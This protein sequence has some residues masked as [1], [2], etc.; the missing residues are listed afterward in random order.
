MGRFVLLALV[1]VS[2]GAM[3]ARLQTVIS[4]LKAPVWMTQAPGQPDRFYVVE[5]RGRILAVTRGS[6]EKQV[7]LDI[8]R[9]VV[10][11]GE[12]GLLSVAFH[13]DFARNG[14]YFVNYTA[15]TPSFGNVIAEYTVGSSEE[16]VLLHIP[17]PWTNHN[18]GLLLFGKDGYLY[19]GTGDGGDAG[20]PMG[21]G[22]N[23]NALLAKILRI[24]V[25]SGDPYGIPADNPFA[26]GGGRG[27]VY[28]Y[29]LRNPWRFSFDRVTNALFAGDVGQDKWEEIDV[30]E[31]GGN[32][33]WNTMEGNHCFNPPSGC[34]TTGLRL[35]IWEYPH[36]E[37][38][39]VIG[40]YVYRGS[41]LPELRGAYVYGDYGNGRIWALRYDQRSRETVA[42]D[43]LLE[44]RLP[45]SSFAE[46]DRGELYVLALDGK[47]FKIA[48]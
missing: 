34:D 45:I 38:I 40:G 21:N 47:V 30:V 11:G 43:L 8:R 9:N 35:P 48:K 37:G 31:K 6:G 26:Q 32:Y 42:N 44:S 33:G 7:F 14:R 39:S 15:E 17:K 5:Q 12:A 36:S 10:Y 16:K 1:L 46:D 2:P 27:E 13:P 3:A 22:Q 20:D 28:A 23:R 41:E 29:G 18:G 4:G 25:N 19:I 24:D